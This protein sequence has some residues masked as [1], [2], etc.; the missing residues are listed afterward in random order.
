VS[1]NETYLGDPQE[2][3]LESSSV[4]GLKMLSKRAMKT[5]SLKMQGG[6]FGG[7]LKRSAQI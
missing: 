1:C 7:S 6:V 4:A 3:V 5:G 2:V